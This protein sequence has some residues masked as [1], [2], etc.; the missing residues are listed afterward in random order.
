MRMCDESSIL[1]PHRCVGR[2]FG[3]V[4]AVYY[5]LPTSAKLGYIS[6]PINNSVFTYNVRPLCLACKYFLSFYMDHLMSD[7]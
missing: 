2:V 7:I 6:F 1:V 5:P 3:N 4:P